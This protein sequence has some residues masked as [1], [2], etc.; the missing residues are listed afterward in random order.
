MPDQEAVERMARELFEAKRTSSMKAMSQA[1][2][3]WLDVAARALELQEAACAPL[4]ERIA[5]LEKGN[6]R[7]I[8]EIILAE[9]HEDLTAERAKSARLA[10]ALKNFDVGYTFSYVAKEALASTDALAWLKA[11]ESVA[12]AQALEKAAECPMGHTIKMKDNQYELVALACN[13]QEQAAKIRAAA[14]QD[15]AGA[16]K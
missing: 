9:L 2:D 1:N 14:G 16:T 13:L 10:E 3:P 5:E 15:A 6:M 8:T 12:A 4:R 11:R 7:Q